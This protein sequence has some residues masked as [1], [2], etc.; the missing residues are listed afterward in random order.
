MF[1]SQTGED[2]LLAE[3]FAS[4]QSGYF[5]E[6]GAFNGVDHSNSYY[7]EQIGWHGV[8]V[9][10]NPKL[11]AQC[12][13]A[14]PNSQVFECAVVAP[15]SPATVM[16]EVA[17]GD[18]ALSSLAIT[19]DMMRRV[20]GRKLTRIEV[21]T[22]TLDSIL[23]DSKLPSIDFMTIDVEGHELQALQGLSL[24]KW[25]PDV[26]ILERNMHFPDPKIMRIMHGHGYILERTT[27]VND[28]FIRSTPAVARSASYR[29]T[30]FVRYFLPKLASAW[31]AVL[32][33]LLIRVGILK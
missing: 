1:M 8:L 3:R 21:T 17:E 16:F 9:E 27:G 10:A 12:R 15:G 19:R 24:G 25:Q 13:E 33:A 7:F 30:L 31:K 29:A 22:R 6:V 11:A 5:V 20:P 28:W 4:R 2:R 18:L 23:Q 32:R 26:L 14:R